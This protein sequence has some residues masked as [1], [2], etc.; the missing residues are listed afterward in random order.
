M[1]SLQ[2]TELWIFLAEPYA[3]TSECKFSAFA[4]EEKRTLS[5]RR[6]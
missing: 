3:D 2:T 5:L 1:I 6:V 4:Y